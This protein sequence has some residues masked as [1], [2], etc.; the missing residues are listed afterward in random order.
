MTDEDDL[1]RELN[2]K[3]DSMQQDINDIQGDVN[4]LSTLNKEIHRDKLINLIEGKFGTSDAKRLVWYFANGERSP[5]E[6][7]EMV[8][9]GRSSVYWA[10]NQLNREGLVNKTEVDNTEYY[11]KAEIT[12]DL[13][14]EQ[15]IEEEFDDL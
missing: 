6:I 13:G 9:M 4:I 10:L 2:Q 15:R 5:Q 3:A 1:L 7:V 12:L 8:D 14:F 11:D